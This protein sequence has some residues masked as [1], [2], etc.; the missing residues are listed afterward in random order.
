VTWNISLNEVFDQLYRV[1]RSGWTI[2]AA[3]AA[4]FCLHLNLL[5]INMK[6]STGP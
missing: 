6:A 3:A 2:I 4:S 1:V 5:K